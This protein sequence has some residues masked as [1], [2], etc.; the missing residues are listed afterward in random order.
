MSDGRR[1][2]RR[3]RHD[4][5]ILLLAL[6]AGAPGSLVALSMLW[7]GDHS[8]K[9]RW[10]LSLFIGGAWLTFAFMVRSRVVRPLQTI[11]NLVA[12][13]REGDY[14]IRA[15]GANFDDALGLALA[16]INL[17]GAPLREE[18]LG[19]REATALLRR[20][21]S[22]IDVAIFAFDHDGRLRLANRTGER[23]LAQPSERPAVPPARSNS[24]GLVQRTAT[25]T[26]VKLDCT[27]GL[28]VSKYW[29]AP[30]VAAGR[31]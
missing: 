6:T 17:L 20:I 10:T 31:L 7:F 14:S 30:K 5:E 2:A 9:V 25:S 24:R 28:F 29:S 1:R 21:V 16:E 26:P 18:R 27:S 23:M 3:L 22:E 13:L 11:S 15:R 4:S 12:A 8:D 19:A